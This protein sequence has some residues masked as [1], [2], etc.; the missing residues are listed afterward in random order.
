MSV[1]TGDDSSPVNPEFK[2][3][4]TYYP[5][6]WKKLIQLPAAPQEPA[7]SPTILQGNP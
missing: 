6:L 7:A 3:H 1:Y 5:Y 4:P 2:D